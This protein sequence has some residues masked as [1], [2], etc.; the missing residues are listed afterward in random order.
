MFNVLT[1]RTCRRFLRLAPFPVCRKYF[2]NLFPN[3]QSSACP[4]C[5][6]FHPADP[7]KNKKNKKERGD[8]I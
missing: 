2:R 3:G 4:F 8:R 5:C 7:V 1:D 6:C